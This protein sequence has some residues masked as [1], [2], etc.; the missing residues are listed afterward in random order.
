MKI[1]TEAFEGFTL[2]YF[3][4]QLGGQQFEFLMVVFMRDYSSV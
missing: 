4:S 1:V 2:S 3:N